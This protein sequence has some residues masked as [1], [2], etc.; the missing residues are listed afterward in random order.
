VQNLLKRIWVAQKNP[1]QKTLGSFSAPGSA[2]A[3]GSLR[4][5]RVDPSVPIGSDLSAV[6]AAYWT[7]AG[8]LAA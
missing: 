2:K 5:V 6:A 8:M 1:V 4:D 3:A 7:F